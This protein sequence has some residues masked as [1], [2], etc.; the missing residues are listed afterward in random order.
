VSFASNLLNILLHEKHPL[1][2]LPWFALLARI[3]AKRLIRN[4]LSIVFFFTTH[5][6]GPFSVVM[7]KC[8]K[9]DAL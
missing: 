9:L 7:T 1:W 3:K 8:L 6:V 2:L 5:C 4:N